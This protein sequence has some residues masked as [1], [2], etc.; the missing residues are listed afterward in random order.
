MEFVILLGAQLLGALLLGVLG[1]AVGRRAMSAFR[2][3]R[4]S[5][6]VALTS[7]I[8]AMAIY[9]SPASSSSSTH[10]TCFW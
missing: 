8:V 1:G 5:Q 4:S 7:R 6:P 3:L 10:S 2:W 9:W